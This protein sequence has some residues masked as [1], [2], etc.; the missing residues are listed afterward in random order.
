MVTSIVSSTGYCLDLRR[1]QQHLALGGR[2]T[3]VEIEYRTKI[4]MSI[5]N[6]EWEHRVDGSVV[7][8]K[9]TVGHVGL[10]YPET[11]CLPRR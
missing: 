3:K 9:R 10:L 6:V 1:H 5:D 4:E 2:Q 8:P 11:A 7:R